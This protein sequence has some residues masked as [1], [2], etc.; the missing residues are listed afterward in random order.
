M[1]LASLLLCAAVGCAVLTLS[2]N[3]GLAPAAAES[4]PAVKYHCPMH[5]SYV[6]DRKGDCP[7][8]GMK[9]VP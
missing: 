2:V 8:C 7:V 1:K 6:Q 5:P 3:G 4:P 9:L